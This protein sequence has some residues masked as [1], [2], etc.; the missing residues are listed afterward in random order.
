M[1]TSVIW[2]NLEDI[3]EMWAQKLREER[4]VFT[5]ALPS[6][7]VLSTEAGH[8]KDTA[9]MLL[10]DQTYR[11]NLWDISHQATGFVVH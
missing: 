1:D 5:K 9:D 8:G 11:R 6:L 7:L 2:E 4:R 10:P 3:L